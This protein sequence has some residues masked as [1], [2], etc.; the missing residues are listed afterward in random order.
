MLRN[1][2]GKQDTSPQ[3][4]TMANTI[5]ISQFKETLGRYPSVLAA[6]SRAPKEGAPSIQELDKFRYIEAPSRLSK[7]SKR[8]MTI[9]D[10]NKLVQ[11]KLNHGAYRPGLSKRVAS[12]TDEKIEE[13]TEDGFSHYAK[14][15][16]DIKVVIEK[17]S[18]LNGIGPATA[19]LLLAIHDPDNVIFFSDEVYSWLVNNGK[20]STLKYTIK[21]FEEV[22]TKA[23]ALHRRL[24]VNYIDIEKVAFVTIKENEPVHVP[25]PKKEP[26]GLPRG[27]PKLAEADKKPKKEPS[28]LPRGRPRNPESNAKPKATETPG[29]RGRSAGVKAEAKSPATAKTPATPASGKGRGRRK[30]VEAEFDAEGEVDDTPAP[31]SSAKRK[32]A[33]DP[34]PK[35]RGKKAKA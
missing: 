22:Y 13:A 2:F 34:T 6:K 15:P 4:N 5:T 24:G 18:A 11:W 32:A 29:K 25:K 23:E 33:E 21:E 7:N 31:K 10:I 27:R 9:T 20:K 35:G 1:I 3:D 28:G 16:N 14:N 17:L 30:K 8:V 26:S 12:N 19:S